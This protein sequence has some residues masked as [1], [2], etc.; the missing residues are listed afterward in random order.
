MIGYDARKQSYPPLAK[1]ELS[2]RASSPNTPNSREEEDVFRPNGGDQRGRPPSRR[3]AAPPSNSL[4]TLD[5]ESGQD[6][7]FSSAASVTHND[8]VL[9]SGDWGTWQVMAPVNGSKA[10][11]RRREGFDT[12]IVTAL[13]ENLTVLRCAGSPGWSY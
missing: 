9:L 12:R 1:A 2:E 13:L 5:F 10:D 6:R 4:V 11:I 8:V 3:I 7:D